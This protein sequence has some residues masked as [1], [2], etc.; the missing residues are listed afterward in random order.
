VAWS[1]ILVDKLLAATSLV[2]HRATELVR[3]T[4]ARHHA[5]LVLK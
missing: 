1:V 3:L 5:T 4:S 2:E